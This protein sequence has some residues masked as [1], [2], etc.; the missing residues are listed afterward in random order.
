MFSL[1]LF[2]RILSQLSPA[3]KI[4]IE[5][6]WCMSSK[7]SKKLYKEKG[8]WININ[9]ILRHFGIELYFEIFNG[10]CWLHLKC[11][12]SFYVKVT[13]IENISVLVKKE[14]F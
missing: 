12:S 5:L 2:K 13:C 10:T 4:T 6:Y 9:I 8:Y 11:L 3:C 1:K 7:K 14:F